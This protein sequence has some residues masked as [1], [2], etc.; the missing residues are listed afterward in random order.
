MESE[1]LVSLHPR[2]YHMAEDGSWPSIR[3]HGLLSARAL[4]DLFDPGTQLRNE[5]LNGVRR[6]GVNLK[7]P[8]H[9][10]AVVRDQ[11][12]L[13][14]VTQR[15]TAGTTVQ[16]FLD[17]LNGHT[18]FWLSEGRLQRLLAARRYRRAPQ[19][20]L[21]LDTRSLIG[22]HGDR[23]KLTP[24]NTGSVHVPNAP[25]RGAETFVPLGQYP[26]QEWRQRRGMNADAVV[27]LAVEYAVPDVRDHVI[28]VSRWHEGR[29]LETV[30]AP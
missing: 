19:T 18:F 2:L 10:K 1:L 30:Y 20:V 28:D 23:I 24:Y 22:R 21:T 3:E 13:K 26:Y 17:V 29:K 15:L 16:Q 11:G 4:V 5:V 9:G 7:H 25:L 12:P 27:E 14:F 6:R 8:V